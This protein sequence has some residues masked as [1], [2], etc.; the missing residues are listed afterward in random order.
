[1][2]PQ[3]AQL[4]GSPPSGDRW[5][6][7]QKFD[8]YRV[9]AQVADGNVRIWSR[10]AVDWTSRLPTLARAIAQLGVGDGAF[11]GELVVGN[12]RPEDFN[13]LQAALA[14]GD[15]KSLR[16]MLF[17]LLHV[18]GVDISAAPLVD[19]KALLDDVLGATPPP[20]LAYSTHVE[21][22]GEAVFEQAQ[23][24]RLEGIVSKRADAPY[25]PGRGHGW[26]KTK[27]VDSEEFAA[28]GY[29][30]NPGQ[31]S[32]FRSLLLARPTASG[33][34][35]AGR[36]GSGFSQEQLREISQRIGSLGG[37]EPTAEIPDGLAGDLRSAMWFPPLFVVDAFS[38]GRG[39]SG[40][41]RHPSLKAVRLDKSPDD[42]RMGRST[43]AG[44]D[45]PAANARA[46]RASARPRTVIRA[47]REPAGASVPAR[48]AAARP[49]ADAATPPSRPAAPRPD[50]A[51]TAAR[52]APR[53]SAS[54]A[55]TSLRTPPSTPA[56][57]VSS[58]EKI[59]YPDDGITKQD[60][61]DYYLAVMDHLL[62][63][64]RDRP[65]SVIRCPDGAGSKCF[66]QKHQ[67]AG[68]K[69]V[70]SERVKEKKGAAGRYLVVRDAAGLME[71]VQHNALEFHPWG[72]LA[73]DP[74]H[75]DRVVFDLDPGP[76]VGWPA[77]QAAAR[78]L[79]G[80]LGDIGLV[81]YLRTSGGKGL[82]VVVPLR[83]ATHWDTVKSFAKGF[84]VALAGS[85]PER[86]VA[87]ATLAKRPGKIFVDYLRNGRGATAV[88][89]YSLRARPG[90]PVAMPLAW[91]ELASIQSGDAFTMQAALRRLR[92]LKHDP[93][94]GIDDRV[95][96]LSRWT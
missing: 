10:N 31:R 42:L 51:R 66:F 94:A 86:Y 5:I 9:I 39:S 1:M 33:W 8:G 36:V 28:V 43:E 29:T 74:D 81:S 70:D 82:H 92:G 41:L 73:E 54:R 30:R 20:V 80:Y 48:R 18:D 7:E 49:S 57:R 91:D 17:D 40:V 52:Q 27:N 71:L 47:D 44:P 63:H 59:L 26:Q 37:R 62:P 35:Y 84:A 2:E 12:G 53:K 93:W 78:Q 21:G 76:G 61:A 96:D 56:A 24:L 4:G 89:S 34:R 16:F 90:A 69:A 22:H 60:V 46:P 85:E 45:A 88:A 11:D 19:R 79:R 77:I 64:V 87:T 25:R 95:Q 50:R 15:A 75:A 23:R 67:T 38:R 32:G 6:H 68:M 14:A 65:L 13:A 72:A 3:L 55:A 83:P 58:P